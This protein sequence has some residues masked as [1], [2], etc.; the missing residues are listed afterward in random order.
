MNSLEI[1]LSRA[2]E[3]DQVY[4]AYMVQARKRETELA[5]CP[6]L[7]HYRLVTEA[8]WHLAKAKRHALAA[9]RAVTPTRKKNAA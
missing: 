7:D 5:E 3:A 8:Q 9:R 6:C 2:D 1:G 4:A